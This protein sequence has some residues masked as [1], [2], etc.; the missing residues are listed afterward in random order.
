MEKKIVLNRSFEEIKKLSN[1]Y[2]NNRAVLSQIYIKYIPDD[3]A[4]LS[5]LKTELDEDN[6]II[7]SCQYS[8]ED[9]KEY[10]KEKVLEWI[11]EDRKRLKDYGNSWGMIGIQAFCQFYI[12]FDNGNNC[13]YQIQ[14]LSSSGLW[15]IE[16]DSN[17]EHFEE[18]EKEQIEELKNIMDK[19]NIIQE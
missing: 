2:N 13:N 15:G 6:N 11:K 12:P 1:K 17:K 16:S 14:N 5:Y 7:S 8:N 9:F 4:D 10:G 19:L 3:D 18:I